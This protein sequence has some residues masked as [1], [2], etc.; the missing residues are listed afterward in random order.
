MCWSWSLMAGVNCCGECI[1]TEERWVPPLNAVGST[2]N[3]KLRFVTTRQRMS[4]HTCQRLCTSGLYKKW[5]KRLLVLQGREWGNFT[6]KIQFILSYQW[7]L[8]W[9]CLVPWV[10]MPYSDTQSWST[11]LVP[12][13]P[14]HGSTQA[15]VLCGTRWASK[16]I[17]LIP[18]AS[19]NSKSCLHVQHL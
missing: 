13:P 9:A 2:H 10:S 1:V 12:W 4:C 6:E 5:L 15:T 18:Y 14:E 17:H 16:S 3:S 8:A 19:H 11:V 7:H